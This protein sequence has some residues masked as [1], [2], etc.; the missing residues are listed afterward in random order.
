[1]KGGPIVAFLAFSLELD[2]SYNWRKNIRKPVST[3]QVMHPA[4]GLL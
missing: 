4:A 1:M 2:L 3:R